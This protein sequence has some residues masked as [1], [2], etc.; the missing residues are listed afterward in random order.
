MALQ[1]RLDLRQTQSLVMTPQLQQA[2]KLLQMNNLEVNEFI[3]QELGQN[4]LIEKPDMDD[5]APAIEI[6]APAPDHSEADSA[7]MLGRDNIGSTTPLDT[8]SDYDNDYSSDNWRENSG[9]GDFGSD[10]RDFDERHSRDVTLSEHL[11][12]QLVLECKDITERMLAAALVDALDDSGYLTT[13]LG[14]LAQSLGCNLG[15]LEKMRQK[16]LRCEPLGCGARDLAECLSV[17]LAER[18]RLDPAM[19]MLVGNLPLVAARDHARLQK[20]C[21][22]DA[23]DLLDMLAELKRLNP[24]PAMLYGAVSAPTLIPDV[25]LRKMADG[26]WS[27]EL[28]PD[29]LPKVLLRERYYQRLK[30]GAKDK[31]EQD[32]LSERFA[33]ANWLVK[34]LHQRAQTIMKV[35][36]AIV[37]QQEQFF[38]YGLA[39]LKPLILKDIAKATGLHESTISRVTTGKYMSTPRGMFEL[40]YF[41]SVAIGG[42]NG[43]ITHSAEAVRARIKQMIDAETPKNVLSDDDLAAALKKEGMDVARRTVAK[44]RE[45]LGIFSSAQRKRMKRLGQ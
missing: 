32:Y 4:P 34:S 26:S 8:Q 9:S 33:S 23:E 20:L 18:N 41:F 2:I 21:G 28:N 45:G 7:Q 38:A 5:D 43:Q 30:M 36:S 31:R 6:A 24:K 35:A 14:P 40:K 37:E 44:Y 13:D 15:A 27:V 29:T 19:Q 1:Q 11:M 12:A 16:L 39:Y 25:L 22:V 3:E 42:L 10:E 17:Q